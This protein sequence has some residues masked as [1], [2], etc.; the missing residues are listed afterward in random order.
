M[1]IKVC[2]SIL[3]ADF[4]NLGNELRRAEAS[5]CDYIHVDV[6][7]GVFVKNMAIGLCVAQWLPKGTNLRLDA[8]L[9]VCNPQ[10]FIEMFADAGMGAILFHPEAYSHHYA[11]I[12]KIKRK[13]M[14]AGVVLQPSSSIEW[15]RPMLADIDIIDQ[16]A[17][18]AGFPNQAY[19]MVVNDK[20]RELRQLRQEHA[21]HYEIQ[22]DGGIDKATA[23]IAIDAGADVLI[24]G[25]T[26]FESEDMA[27]TVRAMKGI[28]QS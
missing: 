12:E 3:S 6:M 20:L 5:G 13:G 2:A 22:V 24:S 11:L 4:L 23:G 9:A 8:H 16:L 18:N 21:F 19:N 7:D 10:D 27:A 26:L 25:S 28:L 14:L 1:D 17:V 15:I